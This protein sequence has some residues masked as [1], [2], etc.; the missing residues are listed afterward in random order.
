MTALLKHTVTA[1]VG[2]FT[3]SLLSRSICYTSTLGSRSKPSG[4][5]SGCSLNPSTN[6]TRAFELL[7]RHAVFG[8][9]RDNA[10]DNFQ[11]ITSSTDFCTM[12][13]HVHVSF[14]YSF[15]LTLNSISPMTAHLHY[16]RP[17]PRCLWSDEQCEVSA[18]SVLACDIKIV[19]HF[20]G[21]QIPTL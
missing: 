13:Y 19:S 4:L 5:M 1:V 20:P 8:K 17:H 21:Q 9:C 14:W 18:Q 6:T 2:K 12:A 3:F 16:C 11:D 7:V 15:T 10:S